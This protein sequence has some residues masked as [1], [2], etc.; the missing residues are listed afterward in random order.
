MRR[1][2]SQ[3]V[4][5][6]VLVM[7]N[8]VPYRF[9]RDCLTLQNRLL[10]KICTGDLVDWQNVDRLMVQYSADVDALKRAHAVP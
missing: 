7:F 3:Y 6:H 5:M 8:H 4:S 1:Y 9:A 10:P 2:P